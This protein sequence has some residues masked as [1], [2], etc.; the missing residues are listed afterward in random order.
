MLFIDTKYILAAMVL[1]IICF[2]SPQWQH[3]KTKIVSGSVGK[4]Y[5]LNTVAG[6]HDLQ[7]VLF[8]QQNVPHIYLG[9][10]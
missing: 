5:Y 7:I 9:K 3:T 6:Q 2:R 4:Y 1:Y 8:P 10:K